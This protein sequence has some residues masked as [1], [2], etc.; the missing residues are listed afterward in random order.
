MLDVV[1]NRFTVFSL[2]IHYVHRDGALG[3]QARDALLLCMV[4]S[5]NNEAIAEFIAHQS[6]VCPVNYALVYRF[7]YSTALL[8]Q[9]NIYSILPRSGNS[10]IIRPS[11][12]L[13]PKLSTV[14]LMWDSPTE[15]ITDKTKP[16]LK[17]RLH[18]KVNRQRVNSNLKLI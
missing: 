7:L 1:C 18:T 10:Q 3:Q 11:R 15:L 16:K 6:T 17:Q 8:S 13:P 5:K 2:L 4:L 14:Y 9:K 12:Q